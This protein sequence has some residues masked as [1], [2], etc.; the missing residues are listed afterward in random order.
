MAFRI[1]K[2]SSL[3]GILELYIK[4]AYIKLFIH[5]HVER[6]STRRPI[7]CILKTLQIEKY[8]RSF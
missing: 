4:C 5:T 3:F 1:N 7:K 2:Y 6:L 8:T